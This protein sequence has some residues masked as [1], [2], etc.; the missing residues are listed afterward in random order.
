MAQNETAAKAPSAIDRWANQPYRPR[1]TKVLMYVIISLLICFT[2]ARMGM[3]NDSYYMIA[4]GKEIVEDGIPYYNNFTYTQGDRTVV[5]QWLYCIGIYLADLA[6]GNIGLLAFMLAQALLLFHMLERYIAKACPDPF[7][8][9]LGAIVSCTITSLNYIASLRPEN[10]TL[11]LMLAQMNALEDYRESH[12]KKWLLALPAIMLA[13]ANLHVSMW[14]IHVCVYLAYFVPWFVPK[15]EERIQ[16]KE[17]AKFSICPGL[18]ADDGMAPDKWLYGAAVLSVLATFLNPYGLDGVLYLVRSMPV[19]GV[20]G[21]TEQESIV[22]VSKD[23]VMN[24]VM[25]AVLVTLVI[26]RRISATEA[27]IV[28]GFTALACTNYHNTMYMPIAVA[29]LARV[30]LRWLN[31]KKPAKAADVMPNGVKCVLY[32]GL[33]ACVGLTCLS[34]AGM[35]GTFTEKPGM[36][37]V[38]EYIKANQRPGDNIFN[39]MNMGPMMEYKGIKGLFSDTRPE[40]L[41]PGITGLEDEEL[42]LLFP[43]L[44]RRVPSTYTE[45][46]YGNDIRTFLDENNIQFV[47]DSTTFPTLPYLSGWLEGS[48]EWTEIDLGVPDPDDIDAPD[49]RAYRVWIRTERLA[50]Q[51]AQE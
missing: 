51:P 43:W 32:A 33:A 50:E 12:K 8:S 47:A 30:L 49:T 23:G 21:I 42:P 5:Q 48:G 1:G 3:D 13:E 29:V 4:Q 10:I 44:G 2:W 38:I 28:A 27:C 6:P 11:I 9:W 35:V 26:K 37:P 22:M 45:E 34:T 16:L 24:L 36:D 31:E 17:R 19:F 18:L 14:P 40:L 25:I 46:A 7:W 41:M 15:I 20:I 39:N